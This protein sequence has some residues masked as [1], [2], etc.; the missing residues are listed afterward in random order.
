[1]A[2]DTGDGLDEDAPGTTAGTATARRTLWWST[3]SVSAV[4]IALARPEWL[5]L[6]WTR[7]DGPIEYAGFACF[8]A[9]SA[10][11]FVAASRIRQDRRAALAAVA[12]GAVLFVAAGEEISWGQ[13]LLDVETPA[14]L[15]DRNRQDELNLHNIDGL[16]QRAVIAQ[17]AVA[18]GGVVPAVVRAAALG[19]SRRAVLRRVSRIPWCPLGRRR[20]RM[21]S[22]R[23]ERRSRRAPARH[24]SAGAHRAA[25]RRP[26][27]SPRRTPRGIVHLTGDSRARQS[28]WS[29]AGLG[30]PIELLPA[31]RHRWRERLAQQER[32]AQRA[33]GRQRPEELLPLAPGRRRPDRGRWLGAAV[34]TNAAV[35]CGDLS[36]VGAHHSLPSSASE[37][38]IRV[39]AW[40][41]SMR[42]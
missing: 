32:P 3:A 15:V 5:P 6:R 16:Q 36:F 40:T 13:R 21:G 24:R 17:L 42:Y 12:L 34:A 25:G 20:G 1:M 10:L 29:G 37:V 14:A 9:A 18:C 38:R 41:F 19:A 8:L 27:A 28:R 26:P 11:A 39:S 22:R 31:Q 33:R 7:E 2:A 23:E 4:G 30:E 35:A